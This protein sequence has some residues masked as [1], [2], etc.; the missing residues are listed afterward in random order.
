MRSVNATTSGG[1]GLVKRDTNNAT[2]KFII[3]PKV[4]IPSGEIPHQKFSG[5]PGPPNWGL[6]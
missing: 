2:T 1:G 3:I 6:K 5:S 4:P